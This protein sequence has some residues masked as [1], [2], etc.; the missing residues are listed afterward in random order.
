M[1]HFETGN[2]VMTSL[3]YAEHSNFGRDAQRGPRLR[4]RAVA[5]FITECHSQAMSGRV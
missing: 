5:L 3:D 2:G 4:P 1:V